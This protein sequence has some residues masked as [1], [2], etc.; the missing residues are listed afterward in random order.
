MIKDDEIYDNF[1]YT[2]CP[3]CECNKH[4]KEIDYEHI[5]NCID[6]REQYNMEMFLEGN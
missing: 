3:D 4:C 2:V 1:L 5:D 6:G